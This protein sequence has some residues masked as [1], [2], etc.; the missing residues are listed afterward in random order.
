MSTI[1]VSI[2]KGHLNKKQFIEELLKVLVPS[3][4][5]SEVNLLIELLCIDPYKLD[6][7]SRKVLL[8]TDTYKND[9]NAERLVSITM[10]KLCTRRYSKE[11]LCTKVKQGVYH[12]SNTLA[13]QIE[14]LD[15]VPVTKI[16][17]ILTYDPHV[18]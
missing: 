10:K 16:E 14:S 6:Y 4:T 1:K 9:S 18:I 17:Y 13:K 2:N 5:T 7:N 3:L 15:K 12:I 8:S 11:F